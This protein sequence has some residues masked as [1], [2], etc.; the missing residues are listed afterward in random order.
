MSDYFFDL[1]ELVTFSAVSPLDILREQNPDAIPADAPPPAANYRP[2]D[3]KGIA[4]A[5]CAKFVFTGF[6]GADGEGVPKGYCSLWEANVQ[7]DHVSDGFADPG[8]PLDSEG[9]EIWDFADD[10]RAF[11]EVRLNATEVKEESGFVVKEVLRTGEW[12][13]IPTKGG[14]VNKPLRIIRDGRSDPDN[15]VIAMQE[16]VANFEAGA[17][18][19]PQIPLSDD[20]DDHK[21]I[22]RVNTGFVRGLWI[23]GDRL[24]AKLEFTEPEVRDKVL[25]GTYADVSCG[26]PWKVN[27]RGKQYGT[28]VEHIAITNRPF[29][30]GLGPFLAASDKEKKADVVA[31]GEKPE[32]KDG[33]NIGGP[34][35]TATT[36]QI[37]A[38][39]REAIAARDGVKISD[40][41]FAH[42]EG[43]K[44]VFI[45]NHP[46]GTAWTV[47]FEITDTGV[48]L[49]EF[50]KWAVE[51]TEEKPDEPAPRQ[52][53]L[54]DLE[55]AQ[56][57]RAIQLSQRNPIKAKE[58][59]NMGLTRE[60]IE[61]LEL[62]DSDRA[63][64]LS[65]LDENASLRATTREAE[66][67]RRVDEL[68]E[69][70]LSERP[71]FLKLY[72][73]V[74]LSD[75]GGPA[76]ILLSDDGKEKER[77]TALEILDRAIEALK[78]SDGKVALS[79]QHLVDGHHV[80][81][82][83]DAEG[84]QKPFEERLAAAK[85][86]LYGKSQ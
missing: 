79:D 4:C 10:K 45:R 17:I 28:C 53:E 77:L 33:D 78:G 80:K 46:A 22:T 40:Y 64:L 63:A 59:A 73:A 48:S 67:D 49:A 56:R 60:Q 31:F 36:E 34:A 32:D 30:D 50:S 6:E 37:L 54:S 76:V 20:N 42:T 51:E 47:P 27:S 25:R 85:A 44:T 29:I 39:A 55:Q 35:P 83:V 62:S 18:P 86:D 43:E 65:V 69:L 52:T 66:V 7:G 71:G 8:P 2:A 12:P 38:S 5:S 61:A 58:E 3:V 9:N 1:R 15:G 75:D 14:K 19:N 26:I 57:M 81:P 11:A 84:E 70:G 16:L 24:L 13:V 41:G 21:N 74:K 23:D 72:R 82:P 68:K